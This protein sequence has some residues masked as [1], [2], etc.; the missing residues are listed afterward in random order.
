MS[1]VEPTVWSP[2]PIE[3]VWPELTGSPWAPYT[4]TENCVSS[5]EYSIV[6]LM[7]LDESEL[8]SARKRM[9]S[10]DGKVMA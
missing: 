4:E 6:E 9:F 3:S 8:L 1:H 5:D 7:T 2:R 10:D